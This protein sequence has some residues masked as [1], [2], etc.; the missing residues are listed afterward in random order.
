[1]ETVA[2]AIGNKYLVEIRVLAVASPEPRIVASAAQ[3]FSASHDGRAIVAI[4]MWINT[5]MHETN[6][7][8]QAALEK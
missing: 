8:E 5:I 7:H 2:K 4:P 6:W 1:M 3:A